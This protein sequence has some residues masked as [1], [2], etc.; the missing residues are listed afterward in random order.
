MIAYNANTDYLD[1]KL[2]YNKLNT[3]QIEYG[4]TV[5]DRNVLA[6]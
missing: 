1:T 2:N 5:L 6:L 4:E 3:T